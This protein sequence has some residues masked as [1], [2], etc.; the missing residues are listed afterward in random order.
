MGLL[1]DSIR[2]ALLGQVGRVPAKPWDEDEPTFDLHERGRRMGLLGREPTPIELK[3]MSLL[4]VPTMLDESIAALS[5]TLPQHVGNEAQMRTVVHEAVS[6]LSHFGGIEIR[7]ETN[8]QGVALPLALERPIDVTRPVEVLM[9]DFAFDVQQAKAQIDRQLS[10]KRLSDEVLEEATHEMTVDRLGPA[11]RR[12]ARRA[13]N[14][15]YTFGRAVEATRLFRPAFKSIR[16]A[17]LEE[18][19]LAE[20]EEI[21]AEIAFAA[22]LATAAALT[23]VVSV[24]PGNASAVSRATTAIGQAARAATTPEATAAVQG[25]ADA[26]ED[27]ASASGPRNAR[28]AAVVAADAAAD[29][30]DIATQTSA[31]AEVLREAEEASRARAALIAGAAFITIH[32]VQHTAV[33]DRRTCDQCGHVD[34]ETMM[35]GTSRQLELEPPYFRCRGGDRC[36][37][38]H[39]FLI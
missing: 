29:I 25:L 37:C 36:R 14:I 23:R 20:P 6:S 22:A 33:M 11:V 19:S 13:T 32:F 4:T 16:E 7:R 28:A 17:P 35:L 21:E 5:A 18:R 10:R 31:A 39:I 34:G 3:V 15:G 8:R 27:I 2:R 9:D 1:G 26:V 38:Q 12:L 24:D 30:A